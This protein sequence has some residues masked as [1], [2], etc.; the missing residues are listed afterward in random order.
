MLDRALLRDPDGQARLRDALARRGEDPAVVDQLVELD[1]ERRALIREVDELR[2][3]RNQVSREIAGLKASGK[4]E[5]A[6]QRIAESQELGGRLKSLE[7]RRRELEEA[8]EK[9]WLL[10]PNIPHET[11]PVGPDET[12][13]VVVRTWGE[14]TTFDFEPRPHWELGELLG[15]LDFDSARNMSGSRFVTY[16][17]LGARLERALIQFFLDVHTQEHGYTEIFPPILV[18]EEAL[19]ASGHLPKFREEMYH[20]PADDLYLIPTA[21]ASL[22]NLHRDQILDE[23]QLPLHYTAYTPCFRREAGAY[24]KDVRGM[25]RVHQFNKVELFKFTLPEQSYEELERMLQHA[26]T[27]LQRLGIPYRVVALSTGDLGFAAAKTYDIEAWAPGQ[28]RWLEVS[29]VSN[30][31]AFQARRARTRVRRADGTVEYVHTLNG[32]GLATPRTFIALL[33]NFQQ[34]D[35]SV[36]IPDVLRP[37]MDGLER[38]TPEAKPTRS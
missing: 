2:T 25:I 17:G 8:F 6:E 1:R 9:A 11:V 33:E 3:R 29:S 5:E 4:H 7:A 34:P 21:E 28:K 14:P 18:R 32:S 30:T 31:E 10:I 20:M 19:V 38:L 27:I 22:A 23:Q 15:I 16:R 26:E 12:A 35:G 36:I 37:Y 13:N 24:G